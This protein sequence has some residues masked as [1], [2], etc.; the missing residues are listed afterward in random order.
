MDLVELGVDFQTV[1]VKSPSFPVDKGTLRDNF[2]DA[3]VQ[4]ESNKLSFTALSNPL[5]YYGHILEV[6]PRIRYK[7][8]KKS[9][10]QYTY[11]KF[12]HPNRHY[13]Y[14]EKCID[15]SVIPFIENKYG[16]KRI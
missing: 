1:L 14:I 10:G 3:G 4:Y 8:R 16:V 2:F 13:M 6:A 15:N 9:K 5:I 7:I 11:K 12:E